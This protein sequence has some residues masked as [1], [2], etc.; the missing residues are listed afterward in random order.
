[1]I[2]NMMELLVVLVLGD[3]CSV[4]K[5]W[6]ARESRHQCNAKGD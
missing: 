3:D 5:A 4:P 6:I 1:M 2:D